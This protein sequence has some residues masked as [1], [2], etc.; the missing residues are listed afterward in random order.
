PQVSG[1]IME[2]R[3]VEGQEVKKGDILLVIDPRPFQASLEQAQGQLKSDQAQL[4]LN[5]RNLQRAEQ[6]GQ[7]RF[8]SAQEVDTDRAQVQIYEGAIIRDQAAIDQ[9]NLNLE[10]CYVRSPIDGRTGRRLVDAG[11]FV[12]TGGAI[13]V[14][15]QRQDPLYVDFTVSENELA[16]VRQNMAEGNRLTVGAVVPSKPDVV[17][18]GTLSFLDNSVSTQSGTAMLRATIPNPDRFLWP[19]QYVDVTLTLTILNHAPVVP[20]QT[21]QIGGKGT[22][23]FTVGQDN[24]VEQRLVTQGVRYHDLVVVSQGVKPG[25]TVVVEGQLA[26][27]SGMKVNPQPYPTAAPEK[28]G[29]TE[30]G[31]QKNATSESKQ[32]PVATKT[33]PAL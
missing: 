13:L 30:S 33:E 22:Y 8:V 23:L 29:L 25:E 5:R 3:F 15:I 14:N 24:K 6:T 32:E 10:Y 20:S 11:N 2:V 12:A 9:A 28:S 19:G 21:V 26:L 27:A 7:G 17:K 1:R 4:E 16:R 31:P 18:A